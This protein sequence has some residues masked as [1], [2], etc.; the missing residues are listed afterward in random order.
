MVY[1]DGKYNGEWKNGLREG[2]G[3]Y[4]YNNGEKYTRSYCKR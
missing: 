3:I 2:L 1:F 4:K